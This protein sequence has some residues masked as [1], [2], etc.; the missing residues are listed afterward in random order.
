MTA[1]CSALAAV[2][3]NWQRLTVWRRGAIVSAF[4]VGPRSARYASE[5]LHHHLPVITAAYKST[6]SSQTQTQRT[7]SPRRLRNALLVRNATDT[8]SSEE[9]CFVHLAHACKMLACKRKGE[10]ASAAIIYSS[11]EGVCGWILVSCSSPSLKCCHQIESVT[12]QDKGCTDLRRIERWRRFRH[13][14]CF[15]TCR[16]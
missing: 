10:I 3:R 16:E 5:R 9:P 4:S 13:V 11:Q 14:R 6:T 1:P 2:R 7:Q 8:R 12:F 15:N